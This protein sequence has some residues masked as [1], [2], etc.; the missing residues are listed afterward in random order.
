M[1]PG[2]RRH[3]DTRPN[4]IDPEVALAVALAN[5]PGRYAILAGAG[6][7]R[8]AGIPTGTAVLEELIRQIAAARR[9]TITDAAVTWYRNTVGE[10]PTYSGVLEGLSTTAAG[11]ADLLR[12]FFEPT[13]EDRMRGR[14]VPTAAHHSVARLAASGHLSVILTTNF[15]TLFEDALGAAGVAPAV[16]RGHR[17]VPGMRPLGPDTCAVIK[18]HGDYRDTATLNTPGELARYESPL[19]DLLRRLLT[20]WGLLIVG[21]SAETDIALPAAMREAPRRYPW[22]FAAHRSL[23]PAAQQL[24]DDCGMAVIQVQSADDLMAS[25]EQSLKAIQRLQRHPFTP[26]LAAESLKPML[27]DQTQQVAATDLVERE[28]ASLA[29][30]MPSLASLIV[31]ST[32]SVTAGVLTDRLRDYDA[33]SE[34]LTHLGA[35]LGAWAGPNYHGLIERVLRGL[36]RA[37][38]TTLSGNYAAILMQRWPAFRFMYAVGIGAARQRNDALF[39]V[40]WRAIEAQTLSNRQRLRPADVMDGAVAVA[41]QGALGQRVHSYFPQQ[42]M[43]A[44]SVREAVRAVCPNDADYQDATDFFDFILMLLDVDD[45]QDPPLEG[46]FGPSRRRARCGPFAY[47]D[48]DWR[49]QDGVNHTK[50]WRQ[51]TAEVARLG[52]DWPMLRAGVCDG[53]LDRLAAAL[54][55]TDEELLS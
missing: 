34:T 21:W 30:M 5:T 26:T 2:S 49:Q 38:P 51:F 23:R 54:D 25:I 35:V 10:E 39:T 50:W 3:G 47:H 27:L 36:I 8:S 16:V 44:L 40:I 11:R 15:D 9:E 1:D 37:A 29:D 48:L 55:R 19:E 20:D 41:I 22:Y 42:A 13:P 24:V 46:L 12:P 7:S 4:V 17:D 53:D 45:R 32:Q 18:L 52:A 31:G 6:I 14:M 33:A 28:Y 43:V